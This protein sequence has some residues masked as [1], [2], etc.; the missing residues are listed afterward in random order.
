MFF[1]QYSSTF[2]NLWKKNLSF[3]TF[4]DYLIFQPIYSSA[5]DFFFFYYKDIFHLFLCFFSVDTFFAFSEYTGSRRKSSFII[6]HIFRTRL[7]RS[8]DIFFCLKVLSGSLIQ[9]CLAAPHIFSVNF[10]FLTP[11]YSYLFLYC[12]ILWDKSFLF[13]WKIRLLQV[14]NSFICKVLCYAIP[15]NN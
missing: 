15:I 4:S 8:A 13:Y 14:F 10:I 5:W 9:N 7:F 1:E 3:H 2:R 6:S 11:I 12:M